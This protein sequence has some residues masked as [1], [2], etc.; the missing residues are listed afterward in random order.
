VPFFLSLISEETNDR[1]LINFYYNTNKQF[2]SYTN[3]INTKTNNK[4]I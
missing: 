3:K 2:T 1:I 4:N